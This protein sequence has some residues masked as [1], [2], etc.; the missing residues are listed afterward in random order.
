LTI[1]KGLINN[2]NNSIVFNIYYFPFD[3]LDAFLLING[4]TIV[5]VRSLSPPEID[6]TIQGNQKGYIL[7]AKDPRDAI[8]FERYERAIGRMLVSDIIKKN[9]ETWTLSIMQNNINNLIISGK[10]HWYINH[11]KIKNNSDYNIS[12]IKEI[13]ENNNLEFI[14][15]STCINFRQIIKFS[16]SI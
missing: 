10:N 9:K 14:N 2:N 8:E 11:E 16:S 6:T 1:E 3:I 4:E 13:I 7:H 12:N 15:I 5:K